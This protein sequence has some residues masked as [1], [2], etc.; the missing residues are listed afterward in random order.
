MINMRMH[1]VIILA[2][3]YALPVSRAFVIPQSQTA[4]TLNNAGVE[5]HLFSDRFGPDRAYE[6]GGDRVHMGHPGEA[7]PSWHSA[8][9]ELYSDRHRRGGS[10]G[11][12]GQGYQTD[13]F[14]PAEGMRG[15]LVQGGNRETF[16]QYGGYN[17]PPQKEVVLQTNG[18][19]L[20]ANLEVWDGPNN[21]PESVK[22]WSQDGAR[23]PFTSVVNNRPGS[24]TSVRNTGPQAFPFEA[25]V[26]AGTLA[27]TAQ[28]FGLGV[29]ANNLYENYGIGT[30]SDQTRLGFSSSSYNNFGRAAASAF[31]AGR[32]IQGD[33]ALETYTIEPNVGSVLITA[34]SEGT[35]IKAIVELWQG[36]GT[37]RQ[38]AEVYTQDGL[39]R[40]F[41]AVLETPG[42]GCTIAIRNVGA[43]AFPMRASVEPYRE[44]QNY[45]RNDFPYR[46]SNYGSGFRNDYRGSMGSFNNN[47]M[48]YRGFGSDFRAGSFAFNNNGMQYRGYGSAD[49]NHYNNNDMQYR[50]YGSDYGRSRSS[51]YD[52]NGWGFHN[53]YLDDY[54]YGPYSNKYNRYSGYGSHYRFGPFESNRNANLGY[55]SGYGRTRPRVDD[56]VQYSGYGP[57]YGRYGSSV[58]DNGMQYRGYESDYGRSGSFYNNN[59]NRGYG[60][61]DYGRS[62]VFSN[63]GIQYRGYGSDGPYNNPYN[64]GYRG[65]SGSDIRMGSSAFND[66]GMP[67]RDYRSDYGRTGYFNDSSGMQYHGFGSSYGRAGRSVFN[68]SDVQYRGF[69]SDFVVNGN[70]RGI[71]GPFDIDFNGS[72]VGPLKSKRNFELKSDIK[73]GPY[74]HAAGVW[75]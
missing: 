18:H 38:I 23:Y 55:G 13:N 65:Y 30:M 42:D 68:D 50:G 53:G 28:N 21:I 66:F 69:G 62:S 14:L 52:S 1:C 67:Y 20:E 3:C 6:Y 40:P 9:M 22:V 4:K 10:M 45:Y 46:E 74:R 60:R 39:D 5:L 71:R 59:A 44:K 16:S 2:L 57:G 11:M 35:P 37:A 31:P 72:R 27:S 56:G 17:Q 12:F 64:N 47:G 29:G 33:G 48:E 32:T 8:P 7:V 49:G 26:R 73:I 41:S 25:G 34:H 51:I 75:Q 19:P 24:T 58:F 36:P 61:S 54:R 63:S 15:T 43:M 70:R